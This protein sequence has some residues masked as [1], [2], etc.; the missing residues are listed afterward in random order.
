MGLPNAQIIRLNAQIGRNGASSGEG[1][2]ALVCGG[3]AIVG[4]AQLN[5]V[6][7]LFSVSA[8]ETL[9][10]TAAYDTANDI[11]VHYHISEFFAMNPTGELQ[12]M[13]V[14]QG[15]T[16]AAMV[17]KT[18]A[19]LKKVLRDG[20][21]RI[22]KAGV[23][24]NPA[25]GYTPTL[26][27]GLDGDVLTAIPLAQALADDEYAEDR[28]INN[29]VIEGREY[30]GA[31]GSAA[32]LR[33]L[34]GGPY[35][36]VSVVIAQDFAKA[37]EDALF[38]KT[39]AVGTYLGIATNKEASECFAQASEKFN[40][41]RTADGRMLAAYLSSGNPLNNLALADINSLHDKG[42]VFTRTFSGIDGVYFNQSS[43]CAPET[44]DFN[45]SEVRDVMNRAVRLTRPVIIPYIN[46]T[47]FVVENGR[48][49]R[50]MTAM[51]EA[52]I[53]EALAAMQSDLSS[54]DFVIVDPANDDAGQP[55]PS[56]LV[57]PTLRYM[58]GLVPKGKAKQI[59]GLIGYVAG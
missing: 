54:L 35:R 55:Y 40:L 33:N 15:T 59:V 4:G 13:L 6:Y 23:V 37:S 36:D 14:P 49:V 1:V 53:R 38:A 32:D 21:G 56:F 52:E 57:T 48:I 2:A 9:L 50:R 5:T 12:I 8:A 29:I 11:L 19:F 24:L 3:V 16:L 26:T 7:K 45:E 42:Y 44:D 43:V 47:N 34:A 25:S 30:N 10:I 22:R 39:A 20:T 27:T 28:P 58:I 18:N 51:I 41:T 31:V 17:T 46:S